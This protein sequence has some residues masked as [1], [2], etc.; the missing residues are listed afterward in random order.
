M[1]ATKTYTA[2]LTALALL[3]VHLDKNDEALAQLQT[4]P[5]AMRQTIDAISGLLPRVERYRYMDHCSVIGRGFNYSTA[6]EIS[7]KITELTQTVA[8]PYSSADFLHGP[9]AMLYRGFPMMVIAPRGSVLED[10]RALI[11]RLVELNSELLIISDEPDLLEVAHLA[12]PLP[13]GLPEWLSP[14]VAVVPG[15]LFSLALAQ[16]R[17]L[18][19]DHPEGLTKVTETW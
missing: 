1:A 6:F 3:S 16:A 7:L 4:L 18:D 14:M 12:L 8:E 13:T 2:S 9:I 5:E 17:G 19:P 10:M 15:Q 11:E